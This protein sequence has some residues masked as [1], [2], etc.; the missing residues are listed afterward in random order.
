MR[1][2]HELNH[3]HIHIDCLRTMKITEYIFLTFY[4]IYIRFLLLSVRKFFSWY[5]LKLN[6]D[7]LAPSNNLWCVFFF[8]GGG[9]GG[10]EVLHYFVLTIG[11][12]LF[13]IFIYIWRVC[14][15]KTISPFLI[16]FKYGHH[17]IIRK[18]SLKWYL[19]HYISRITFEVMIKSI[20]IFFIIFFILQQLK[21]QIS[22]FDKNLLIGFCEQTLHILYIFM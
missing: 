17:R 10:E 15:Q 9:G 3:L 14:S 18:L 19:A 22:K 21:S 16:I 2:W 4:P 7:R 12:F 13:Y 8:G 11:V 20:R 6:L 1:Q 5:W